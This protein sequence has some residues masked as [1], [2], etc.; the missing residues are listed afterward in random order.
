[1]RRGP[2]KGGKGSRGEKGIRDLRVS[3]SAL[4]AATALMV[5]FFIFHFSFLPVRPSAQDHP[6]PDPKS[7]GAEVRK[8]MLTDR[9]LQSQYTFIERRE[10]ISISKLGKVSAGPLK[11]YE[12]YPSVE[13][14]N[15]YK[16]LIAVNGVPLP[17]EDL[18]RQ[19]DK[20]RDDLL[21]EAA[22]RERET[23]Q[24]RERR[25]RKDAKQQAEWDRTLDEVFALYD[26]RLVGRETIDGVVT[27]VATL[28]P[29]PGYR[30]RTEAGALMKKL[31]ARA[32]ISEADYQIVK[33]VAEVT[34]DVTFG[35]GV[36]GR[37]HK[38]TV[39]TFERTKV[40]RE[41]WLPARVEI[42]GTG[43]AL[44]RRFTLNSLTTYSDYRK[45]TVTT[46]EKPGRD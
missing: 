18:A 5:S 2:A 19:D 30:P 15:T 33:V 22:K 26:I 43:R 24:Q 25:L 11:T 6:L 29:K 36:L 23:P 14:G 37:L 38:G 9:E 13:R 8:R 42:R 10:E 32:W 17:P 46:E 39:A 21:R 28:D 34:N 31:R 45:F 40:N 35:W 4:S 12:V 16:R 7:F 1:M 44:F 20:H 27:V 41:V 3:R